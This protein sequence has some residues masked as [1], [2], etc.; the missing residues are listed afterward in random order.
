MR[1]MPLL[2]LLLLSTAL[3]VNATTL[4]E[5][6][7]QRAVNE[8]VE[9]QCQTAE[10]YIC[11]YTTE[12]LIEFRTKYNSLSYD[13]KRCFPLFVTANKTNSFMFS[14]QC[15]T[16][17]GALGVEYMLREYLAKGLA[18]RKCDLV[19]IPKSFQSS[20][21]EMKNLDFL[22]PYCFYYPINTP[23]GC[24]DK[25]EEINKIADQQASGAYWE[26]VVTILLLA[27]IVS[28]PVFIKLNGGLP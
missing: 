1:A 28:I 15:Q 20:S 12:R 9:T 14:T 5:K 22:S 3:A 25:V 4:D 6:I 21:G 27:G 19:N 7:F 10:K 24:V 11:P 18:Q 16:S 17:G 2:F 8:A 23:L 26:G 13:A